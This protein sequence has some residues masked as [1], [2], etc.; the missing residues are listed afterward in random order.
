MPAFDPE[1]AELLT[2]YDALEESLVSSIVT[3]TCESYT[4]NRCRDLL[5]HLDAG[6]T[7][8]YTD[9]NAW[10]VRHLPTAYQT[11]LH[12]GQYEAHKAGVQGGGEFVFHQIPHATLRRLAEE[13]VGQRR[14]FL[15]AILRQSRDYLR[16][17]TAGHIAQGL[18]L[19][20][21]P[22]A[23]GRALRESI[24]DMQRRGELADAIAQGINTATGIIYTDGSVHSIHEYAQMAAHT[25]M[26]AAQN[27]GALDM[28]RNLDV[29][30]LRVSTH[31]TLCFR[32]QPL[33]G[34]VFALDAHGVA[35]GYPLYSIISLPV[36]P[37][38]EHSFLPVDMP[39][40]GDRS[41][42]TWAMGSSKADV[43]EQYA[44]FR[45][46]HDAKYRLSKQGFAS[47][48]QVD[49]WKAG[50]PGVDERDL[51]GP[52]YRY[53]GINARRQSAIA[54]M[55]QL[56]GLSYSDAVGKQTR[57]FMA[58]ERYQRLRTS[59]TPYAQRR[60]TY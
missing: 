55:L 41:A 13:A 15:R 14:L 20:N 31:G 36:H 1:I 6:I 51:R 33:E 60:A 48:G 22:A 44:Q 4:W 59:P 21:S 16:Q 23:V 49:R 39:G 9:A 46:H 24:F 38:C 10:D 5:A 42:P 32:C 58:S 52:R 27:T 8:V 11:G 37:N 18:G 26:M 47:E 3:A 57:A 30:C 17:L 25:G 28:Y 53:A 40:K 50:N 35:L 2:Y 34:A 7:R 45:K 29:H 19:G 54:D 12:A 43:R 56:Q